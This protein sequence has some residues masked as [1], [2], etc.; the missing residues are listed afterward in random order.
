[1][2]FLGTRVIFTCKNLVLFLTSE[3]KMGMQLFV[4]SGPTEEKKILYGETGNYVTNSAQ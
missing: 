3:A 2:I 1:M 4:I